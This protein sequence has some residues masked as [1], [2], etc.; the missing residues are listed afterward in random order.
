LVFGGH[1]KVLSGV[2]SGDGVL[3][4]ENIDRLRRNFRRKC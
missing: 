4:K 1:A 3:L 2:N